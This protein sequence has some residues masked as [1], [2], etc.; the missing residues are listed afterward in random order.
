MESKHVLARLRKRM[1]LTQEELAEQLYVT[2]QAVSR[3]ETGEA[4][5]GIDNLKQLSRL[6]DVSINT[7]LGAPR[8]L[9][10]QCCGM[11]LN[12]EDISRELDGEFNEDF[13]GWCYTEGKMVYGSMEELLAF[14]APHLSAL[15]G[16]QEAEIRKALEAQMKELKNWH[17]A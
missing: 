11:S 6:F 15:H 2:R 10:C 3:W 9:I 1:G 16:R 17:N 7:L 4:A 12:D 14:L 8:K 13:C 5:P